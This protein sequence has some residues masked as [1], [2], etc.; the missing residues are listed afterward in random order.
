MSRKLNEMYEEREEHR[1]RRSA[2]SWK[3]ADA[4]ALRKTGGGTERG[5]MGLQA[6]CSDDSILVPIAVN[7]DRI[8]RVDDIEKIK[9]W[10]T[11]YTLNPKFSRLESRFCISPVRKAL[12]PTR[13]GWSAKEI[14]RDGGQR[15]E[16]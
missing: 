7:H 2:E 4:T 6:S 5:K 8:S 9:S 15:V 1:P 13:S 16:G 12:P 14:E 3:S 10:S 11:T